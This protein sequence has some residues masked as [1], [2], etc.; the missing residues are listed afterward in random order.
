ML[1]L[2][3][4]CPLVSPLDIPEP[5][6]WP[7]FERYVPQILSV[8][9]HCLWPDPPIQPP[10]D[11]ADLLSDL[12]T[13]MWHAGLAEAGHDALETVVDVY[14]REHVPEQDERRSN[15][16]SRLGILISFNGVSDREETLKYRLKAMDIRQKAFDKIPKNKVT[17]ED[18]MRLFNVKS[19]LAFTFLHE[20]RFTDLEPIMDKCYEKYRAW[21]EE[22]ENIP[23]EYAKYYLL[24]SF[25]RMWQK[26]PE[27]AVQFSR[28]GADLVELA[29]GVAHPMTQLWRF[30]LGTILYHA[31]ALQR[32]WEIQEGVRKDRINVCGEF[33]HYTLESYSTCAA[34]LMR[35]DRLDEAE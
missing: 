26:Q 25:V 21:D 33:N 11:F 13:Y 32:A 6:K 23:Y 8:R 3:R 14:D 24:M 20:E 35:L 19:D 17:R 15:V 34:L 2:R 31:G 9:S 16:Y 27:V 12:A 30:A 7:E 5:E 28:R 22:E 4:G 18:E 10:I 1:L 29:A